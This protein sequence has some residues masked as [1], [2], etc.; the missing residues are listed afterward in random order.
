MIIKTD[1]MHVLHKL[2]IFQLCSMT[3]TNHTTET[4]PIRKHIDIKIKTKL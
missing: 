3:L 4:S 2:G 1:M